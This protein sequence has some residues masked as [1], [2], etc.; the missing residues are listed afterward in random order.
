MADDQFFN[1]ISLLDRSGTNTGLFEVHSGCLLWKKQGGS[2][3]VEVDIA[4]IVRITWMKVPRSNQLGVQVNNGVK[5]K[6]DGFRDQDVSSLI[7]FFQNSCSITAEEKQLSVSGK[8]WGEFDINGNMLSF[9]VGS[10]QAFEV[11]LA[12]VS[13]TQIQGKDDVVLEFRK[14]DI[15]GANET[16]SLVEMSF[17]I[18]SSNTQF[19]GDKN[20][21][22]A[23][24]FLKNIQSMAVVGVGGEEAFVTFDTVTILTPRG[25][26]D[27]ELHLS[28][29]RLQGQ[30]NDFKI[31]YSSIVRVFILPKCNTPHTFVVITL[32]PPIRKGQTLYPHIVIQF[33]TDYVVESKLALN[34]DLYSSKYKDK[35]GPY[36]KGLIPEVFTV[37]LHGLSSRKLTRPGKFRSCQD[38]FAVKSSLKAEYGLL[39]PL[40]KCFFFLPK[41]PTLILHDEIEYIQF[42]RHVAGGSNMHYFDLLIRLKMKQEH[43]FRSIQSNEYH[44]LFDFISSKGLKIM[45]LGGGQATGGVVA[46][47][48]DEVNEADGE[49]SDE[50]K[51]A[52]AS[53][54]RK[55]KEKKKEDP[56]E[57]M[58]GFMFFTHLERENVKKHSPGI[59][60]K[61][62]A[63]ILGDRWDK[64]SAE[65]KASYGVRAWEWECENE[66]K[67]QS[68][69]GR[70]S[71]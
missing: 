58:S 66:N 41:P 5:Y 26:Y 12:D 51:E 43:L 53:L 42:E 16:D 29:L 54:S 67:N 57:T 3:S 37:I 69:S 33:E 30:A 18:P 23:Q 11:S 32:D 25:R 46:A 20:N 59:T 21:S 61:N 70:S 34:E 14:D 4:D 13:Q 65:E 31:H 55:G 22:P 45:N 9:L 64:L 19:V 47:Q 39:Y 17:H 50:E 10:K 68:S 52:K 49:E 36:Y 27:V 60:I 35:L 48:Q 28:F 2:K 7:N 62:L 63:R 56:K 44:N 24:V 71:D 8:N 38:G 15:T 1:N 40:E 6:F